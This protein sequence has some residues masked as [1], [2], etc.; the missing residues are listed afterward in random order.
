MDICNQIRAD[1]SKIK[2]RKNDKPKFFARFTPQKINEKNYRKREGKDSN[3]KKKRNSMTS[4][5]LT[6]I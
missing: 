5:L 2:G 1:I 6:P 3:L 4:H